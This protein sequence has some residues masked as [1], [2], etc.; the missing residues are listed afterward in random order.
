[1]KI[2]SSEFRSNI[3]N[4]QGD[5]KRNR[6]CWGATTTG[7]RRKIELIPGCQLNYAR[8]VPSSSKLITW[9]VNDSQRMAFG[10]S[11]A[12]I[13]CRANGQPFPIFD[14]VPAE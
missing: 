7:P 2:C 10:R 11:F 9:Y 8:G 1:M 14:I 12:A 6:N 13:P 5:V 3:G 4:F